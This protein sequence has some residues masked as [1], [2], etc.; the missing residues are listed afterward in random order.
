MLKERQ[1][2]SGGVDIP[3]EVLSAESE[4]GG[5]VGRNYGLNYEYSVRLDVGIRRVPDMPT[6]FELMQQGALPRPP[7]RR[8]HLPASRPALPE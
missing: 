3:V 8:L 7:D 4:G 1:C 2:P 5:Y 6:G